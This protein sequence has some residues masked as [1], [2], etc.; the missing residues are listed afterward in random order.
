MNDLVDSHRPADVQSTMDTM[1][2]LLLTVLALSQEDYKGPVSHAIPK[3]L[4]G[5]YRKA[6]KLEYIANN[7]GL[8]LDEMGCVT[9]ENAGHVYPFT[10]KA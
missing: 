5:A 9:L 1:T 8:F 4:M 7:K 3:R 10:V 6:L 2:E